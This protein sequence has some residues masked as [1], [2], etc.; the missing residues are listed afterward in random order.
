ML[1]ILFFTQLFYPAIYGGGEYMIYLIARELAN[2]GHD[3]HVITQRLNEM[4]EFEIIDRIKIHRVGSPIRFS[5]TLPYTIRDNLRYLIN[6][7]IKGIQ[8]I[9][10]NN[11][12]IDII[13]ANTYI[14]VISGYI[15]SKLYNIPCIITCHDLYQAGDK[16]FWYK[17]MHRSNMHFPFYKAYL[18][19]FI[20]KMILRF[21][22]SAFHTVSEASKE[23]LIKFGVKPGK[24]IVIPNGLDP[25]EYIYEITPYD[26]NEPIAVYIGRLVFYKNLETVIRA[27]KEVIKIVPNAKL[28]LVGD[29]PHKNRLIKE[30]EPFQNN[31]IF[32]GIVSHHEKIEILKKSSFIVFPSLIEGFGI[33]AIEGFACGKPVL[34]SNIRPLSDI[35]IDG[36]NG[37][38]IDPFD[39][40]GWA[41]K[42][43]ELFYDHNK[44]LEMGINA[45]KEFLSKYNIKR[46]TNLVERLYYETCT[47]KE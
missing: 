28:I 40:Y 2:K 36:Y 25:A 43:I 8:I 26:K 33:L 7:I 1:K 29:G 12:K 30:A 13:H 22:V 37:F 41:Q 19:S 14:P 23:D 5:G 44:R 35:V 46:I 9:K 34:V 3:V 24:I 47:K 20:E 38:I 4:T 6:S 21:N 42:M 32:T 45:R 17:W 16:N 27:F 10:E 15:C 11:G 39:V 18:A 31:I